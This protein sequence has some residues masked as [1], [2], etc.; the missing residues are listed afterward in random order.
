M[1]KKKDN[2]VSSFYFKDYKSFFASLLLFGGNLPSRMITNI[3]FAKIKIDSAPP[4]N[5]ITDAIPRIRR[6]R[7]GVSGLASNVGPSVR[8]RTARS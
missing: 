4:A 5:P 6:T 2:V 7:I 1:S 8:N 3:M